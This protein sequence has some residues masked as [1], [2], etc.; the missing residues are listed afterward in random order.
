MQTVRDYREK[1]MIFQAKPRPKEE[2]Q[3]TI[4]NNL[5]LNVLS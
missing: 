2:K 1:N 5:I 4:S 3:Q